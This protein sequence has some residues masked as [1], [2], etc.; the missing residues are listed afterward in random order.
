MKNEINFARLKNFIDGEWIEE[1]T[2]DYMPV[3][4]PSTGEVIGE[5][6]ISSR[7]S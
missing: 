5:V 4:N 1:T 7:E 6:P 2:A 3:Y